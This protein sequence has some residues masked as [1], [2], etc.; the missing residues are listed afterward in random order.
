M[1][2]F[3]FHLGGQMP[4]FFFHLGGQMPPIFIRESGCLRFFYSG[5]QMPPFLFLFG[6][7]DAFIFIFIEVIKELPITLI[8]KPFGTNTLATKIYEYT[9]EGEWEK[10]AQLSIA[11]LILLIPMTLVFR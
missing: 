10:A 7:A 5:G 6:R 11:L 1:P 8:L 2:P 3:F 4:P 9:T